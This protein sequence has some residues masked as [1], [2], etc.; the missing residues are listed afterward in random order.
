MV[1]PRLL[2]FGLKQPKPVFTAMAPRRRSKLVRNK[3]P[4]LLSAALFSRT[5]LPVVPRSCTVLSK[6]VARRSGSEWTVAG[7]VIRYWTTFRRTNRR[8]NRRRHGTGLIHDC[9]GSRG[10]NLVL[11]RVSLATTYLLGARNTNPSTP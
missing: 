1:G 5:G 3:R 6:A 7:L 2:R 11:R 8:E 4:M 10:R 9:C